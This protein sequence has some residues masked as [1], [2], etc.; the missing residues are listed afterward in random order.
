MGLTTQS[1]G[2]TGALQRQPGY[3]TTAGGAAYVIFGNDL[4]AAV[5]HA[6]DGTNNTLQGSPDKDIMVGGQGDDVLVGAGG[7]DVLRG[8]QGD[9][10]LA[11]AD[12][13]F[14]RIVGGNGTD[15]LRLD[16][17]GITLDLTTIA[18]QRIKGIEAIDLTGTGA[19]T[20]MLN[21]RETLEISDEAN[22][23]VICGDAGD[24]VRLDSGWSLIDTQL[25]GGA[26]CDV[27]V[28]GVARL[29]IH[30]VLTV[31]LPPAAPLLTGPQS[32]TVDTTPDHHV[33]QRP[34]RGRL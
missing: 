4:S 18:N 8:G 17:A 26:S 33:E 22:E 19:N 29:F 6:G 2:A 28:Q 16:G 11:I 30:Q 7:P 24:Q 32:L 23:L 5:S 3:L 10:V 15:T 13:D 21:C 20:L 27:Y 25:L 12:L 34:R 9:D 31:H 1:L 14:A